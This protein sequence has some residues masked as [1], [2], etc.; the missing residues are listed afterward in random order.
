MKVQSGLTQVGMENGLGQKLPQRQKDHNQKEITIPE[1]KKV[2]KSESSDEGYV[3]HATNEER[4]HAIAQSG[5]KT[6]KPNAFTDQT[7]WPD[8]NTEKRNYFTKTAEHTW[9]FA[10]EEGKPV[11]IRTK[12]D[13][14]FK[15]E[16]TGDMYTKKIIKANQIEVL[17]KDGQWHPISK[18]NLRNKP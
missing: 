15:T 7:T 3:Y 18:L 11:L 9:Q 1:L 10:P 4:A 13:A 2:D 8:G 6:H 14:D 16:S 12:P 5:L 17:G